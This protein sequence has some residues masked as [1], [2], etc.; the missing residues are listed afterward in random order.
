MYCAILLLRFYLHCFFCLLLLLP[1]QP[2]ETHSQ[3]NP[4]ALCPRLLLWLISSS[5]E[6]WLSL[7]GQEIISVFTVQP[8]EPDPGKPSQPSRSHTARTKTVGVS[9]FLMWCGF[10]FTKLPCWKGEVT[11]HL[12]VSAP[13]PL[14]VH[15]QEYPTI[16]LAAHS[17]PASAFL[18]SF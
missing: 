3:P 8:G 13:C 17:P 12:A 9:R 6:F 5:R 18:L 11:D 1:M 7:E 10:H 2:S 16:S 4:R 14:F 15:S